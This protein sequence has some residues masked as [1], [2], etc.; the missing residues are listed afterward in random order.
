MDLSLSEQQL[1]IST[2]VGRLLSESCP[3][4]RVRRLYESEE[5]FDRA[6]W[7]ELAGLGVAGVLVS[8][9][10]GGS[11]LD[12]IEM[13]LI[14]EQLG[15]VAA[16]VA[17]EMHGLACYAIEH[18]GNDQQKKRWLPLLAS[19]EAVGTVAIQEAD[20]AW[21]SALSTAVFDNGFIKGTK[22]KVP[23]A[24]VADVAVIGCSDGKL[25][26][27][28]T[29]Q[30]SISCKAVGGIDR[31]RK[32]F[33]I[34]F[35]GSPAEL[36]GSSSA[37]I[38]HIALVLLAADAFGCANRLIEMAVA[39]AQERRQFGRPIGQ[40]QAIKHQ[41]AETD[42]SIRSTRGL[43]WHSAKAQAGGGIEAARIALLANAHITD[44][45]FRA[46]RQV[47]EVHGGIGYT[48]ECDVQLF[49]KRALFDRQYLGSPSSKRTQYAR[50]SGW[51]T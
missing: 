12:I 37:S 26:L 2:S 20:G 30:A 41:L 42:L 48:W 31:S 34:D 17:A 18:G 15:H 51:L 5:T 29:D 3:P 28:E 4:E 13:A 10:H 27:V 8:E 47:V 36:L 22:V 50:L 39:Y 33:D 9:E 23:L 7:S 1:L 21:P 40:F 32:L 16:P 43:F 24:D 19:G 14:C 11:G 35:D 44:Q 25:V 45:A 38:S 49:F 6:L 46:A